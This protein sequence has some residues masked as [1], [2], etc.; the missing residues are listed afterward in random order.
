M[1]NVSFG[2]IEQRVDDHENEHMPE[3]VFR[4]CPK[5]SGG[6]IPQA[7]EAEVGGRVR[8][9]FR[10]RMIHQSAYLNIAVL[11]RKGIDNNQRT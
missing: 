9:T 11:S 3:A 10:K 4:G 1:G 2:Q 8:C 6:G 7:F 5:A